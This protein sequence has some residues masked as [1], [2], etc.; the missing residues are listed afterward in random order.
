MNKAR[1][2]SIGTMY[3]DINCI[4]FPFQ[5]GLFANRETTGNEYV[6]QLGGSALNFAKM[7]TQLGLSTTFVG[8][9]GNDPMGE[10]LRAMLKQNNIHPAVIIDAK[11]Q[12]NLAIHYVHKDGSSIMTSAGNANQSLNVNE[13]E[14]QMTHYI[15][16]IDYLYLGGVFKLKKL[17]PY[18][19]RLAKIAKQKGKQIVLDHGRVNNNVSAEDIEALY[20]LMPYVDIYLPSIDEFYDVWKV[21]TI[22]EGVTKVHK[23]GNPI[24][25]IKQGQL[26]AIGIR[27]N[28]EYNVSSFTVSVINTVGAGDSFN[29]GF[30]R[31]ISDDLSFQESIKFACATASLKISTATNFTDADV[32][33]KLNLV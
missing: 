16:T 22:K 19:P 32:Y 18:F 4:H 28:K 10:Q 33:K 24:I 21:K 31:A 2:L 1:L 26:G 5:K 25:V 20:T 7:T 12:T 6:L 3:V 9:V 13:I 11:S 17:L 8:K 30:L 14:D 27:N 29:A 15:D 23:F